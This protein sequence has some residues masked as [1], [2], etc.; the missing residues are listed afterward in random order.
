MT[1]QEVEQEILRILAENNMMF[2]FVV[3]ATVGNKGRKMNMLPS[4]IDEGFEPSFGVIK[5]PKEMLEE[6]QENEE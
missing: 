4:L 2:R 6:E 1:A 3:M 5:I